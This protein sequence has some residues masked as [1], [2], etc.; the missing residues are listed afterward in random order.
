MSVRT[1]RSLQVTWE[2]HLEQST[3]REFRVCTSYFLFFFVFKIK[4]F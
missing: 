4:F 3:V 1:E 2:G